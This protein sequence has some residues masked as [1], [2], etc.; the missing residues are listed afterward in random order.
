MAELSESLLAEIRDL[1]VEIRDLLK[2]R[3]V[4]ARSA[5]V[6]IDQE[7]ENAEGKTWGQYLEEKN[8]KNDF[9]IIALVVDHL[10]STLGRGVEKEEIIEFIRKNPERIK[11][12]EEGKL[13]GAIGNTKASPSYGYIEYEGKNSKSFRLSIKGKQL[14]DR[15]PN[16]NK[17]KK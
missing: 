14:V 17:G 15:L 8:P 2:S 4:S 11:N 10:R 13:S 3:P 9:Q 16:S 7:G 6:V 5:G 1:L 12:V